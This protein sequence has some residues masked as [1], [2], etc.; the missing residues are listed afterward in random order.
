M[1][2]LPAASAA[3]DI[4][5]LAHRAL[6]LRHEFD[7][8]FAEPRPEPPQG[9]MDLL[10]VRMGGEPF[11][12]ALRSVA[13][14]FADKKLTRLPGTAPELLG[15]ASFRGNV[16]PVYDLGRLLGFAG[17]AAP[18]WIVAATAGPVAL[19]F[20]GFEGYRRVP[21]DRIASAQEAS[22]TAH[23]RELSRD[24]G[25]RFLVDVDSVVAGL[26]RR[27]RQEHGERQQE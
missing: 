13:G 20:D 19:A 24:G 17:E 5:G 21:Q 4:T 11:A 1:T 25:L 8:S 16:I 18:R 2:R 3:V 6:E 15:L 22:A 27:V 12:I 14:L 7:R 9:F 26:R 23:V 10:A